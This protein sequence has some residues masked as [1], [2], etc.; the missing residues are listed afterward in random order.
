MT[1]DFREEIFTKIAGGFVGVFLYF[2]IL[3]RIIDNIS[4][5]KKEQKS[6]SNIQGAVKYQ[7]EPTPNIYPKPCIKTMYTVNAII[8]MTKLLSSHI[9]ESDAELKRRVIDIIRFCLT[10]EFV[11]SSD[12]NIYGKFF[13]DDDRDEIGLIAL[14]KIARYNLSVVSLPEELLLEA[15]KYDSIVKKD[16]ERKKEHD[17][18]FMKL[19]NIIR[20]RL[21]DI[22][23]KG[24]VSDKIL[25][26]KILE[27]PEFKGKREKG[28]KLF[29]VFNIDNSEVLVSKS[30]TEESIIPMSKGSK[31]FYQN[32]KI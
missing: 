21:H 15:Q 27:L 16:E 18:D 22:I 7:S 14:A 2:E 6:A 8:A 5:N 24:N 4:S 17:T 10:R 19:T 1:T 9:V 26:E 25:I 32:T 11:S 13:G 3:A 12:V 28:G 23:D 29:Y 30:F 20:C 31:L